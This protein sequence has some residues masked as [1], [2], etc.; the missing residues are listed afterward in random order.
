[1]NA[2]TS[3]LLG[4]LLFLGA[5]DGEP[6]G[7]GTLRVTIYGEEFIEEGIPA[8]AFVDGWAVVFDRFIIAVD[9]I[10]ADGE[11]LPGQHVFDLVQA[12]GGAGH[13]VGSLMLPAGTVEELSYRIA[14]AGSDAVAATATDT[15][16]AD[17]QAGGFSLIVEG[18]ATRGEE[19]IALQWGFTTSTRYSPCE[20]KQPLTAGGEARS[21]I[22]IHAD[23]L[24]YDDLE[25][26]VPD[27]AFDLIATADADANGTATNGELHAVDITTQS[28][29]QVGSRDIADLHG[30]IE[31]Q[32]A[33]LGHIDGEGHCATM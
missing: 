21:Q 2:R 26:S 29:Y 16:V 18:T 30:F 6:A 19:S 14:P 4:S 33:T 9:D 20:T 23:H 25:S 28:R 8:D 7:D 17:M 31:A 13:D 27:V 3:S 32:T 24:F 5:C 22:T 10:D 1:M 12:S 15:D 11:P